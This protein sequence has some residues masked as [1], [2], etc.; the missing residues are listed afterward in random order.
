MGKR[1]RPRK[2]NGQ[3]KSY[4]DVFFT[5]FL[6]GLMVVIPWGTAYAYYQ[7]MDEPLIYERGAQE[8]PQA[9][10]MHETIK[11][12]GKK[13]YQEYARK[14][15]RMN[16]VSERWVMFAINVES[17][18]TWNPEIQS[19]VE[20]DYGRE[21]SYGLVQI[22]LPDNPSVTYDQ[23]TD[24][25]Y[26]IDFLIEETKNDNYEWRWKNTYKKYRDKYPL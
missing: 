11:V 10:V 13:E 17:A 26:S 14:Q 9:P 2:K 7:E 1:L 6:I 8:A 21:E 5:N 12:E 22:H 18:N 25:Y 4:K 3:F 19:Y 24:P 15:A 20:Q 23:A 16:G